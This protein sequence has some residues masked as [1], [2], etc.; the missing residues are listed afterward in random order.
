MSRVWISPNFTIFPGAS[1]SSLAWNWPVASGPTDGHRFEIVEHHERPNTLPRASDGGES[2]VACNIRFGFPITFGIVVLGVAE[3]FS[4]ESRQ[5][6]EELL[7]M[8]DSLGIQIG[9]F[10]DRKRSEQELQQTAALLTAVA[11]GTT[12]AVYV[13][14]REG[15]YLLFNNAAAQFV[16]RTVKDVL[17]KDDTALF[18][19]TDA[20]R[21]MAQARSIMES[22]RTETTEEVLTAA[23][24]TRIYLATQAPYRDERGNV[25][26]VVG[27][28]HDITERRLLGTERDAILARLQ[29]HIERM[30]LAYIL[31][32]AELRITDWNPAAERILGYTR[33]EALGM[34]PFD[35]APP[36]FRQQ[37]AE[38]LA[39]IRAGDMTANSVN[40][41]LTKDGRTITCE[42][43]NTPLNSTVGQFVGLLCLAQDVTSRRQSEEALLLRDRA[44][45]AAT[46]GLLITDPGQ[47]DNPIV[48]VSPAFERITGYESDEVL[49]RNCRFLQGKDTDQAAL[50]LV[51]ETVR[52]GQ[53]CTVEL[54][55][56]RKDGTSFWNEL[57]ISPV[58]DVDGRVTHFVGVQAGC[59]TTSGGDW[60]S[61]S[62]RP[63]R[64]MRSVN[65]PGAWPTTSTISSPSLTGTATCSSSACR[66]PTPPANWSPRSTRPGSGRPG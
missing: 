28:A 16:G 49:G 64:W 62:G 34:G 14:D 12:D 43:L 26:G 56:Y 60:R 63:R 19:P 61:S 40:E 9:L 38:I 58:R 39:R 35:L 2:W 15:K 21:V 10:I 32:D 29:L 44:I 53:S 6:D 52:S 23:G 59:V 47:P 22:G 25:I 18:D 54:L 66:R 1:R 3:F 7:R 46:Q 20:Q 24:V 4:R 36:S 65:L 45:R 41:N 51:R 17:G 48:Y 8:F 5:P 33:R 57:S 42:W 11:E 55:N 27:V 37:A 30:P 31:F 13:K 50:A